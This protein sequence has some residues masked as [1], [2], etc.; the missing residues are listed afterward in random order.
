MQNV[1][2]TLEI[3]FGKTVK[4]E[5]RVAK[6]H[7]EELDAVGIYQLNAFNLERFSQV[8]S[9]KVK[10]SGTGLTVLVTVKE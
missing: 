8:E 2:N 6:V 3:A 4:V 7:L 1:K 5:G 10:R 9:V